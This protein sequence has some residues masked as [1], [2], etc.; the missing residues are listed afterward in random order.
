FS[1]FF[2]QIL[3]LLL[4]SGQVENSFSIGVPHSGRYILTHNLYHNSI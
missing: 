1:I 3:N 4:Q 2:Q